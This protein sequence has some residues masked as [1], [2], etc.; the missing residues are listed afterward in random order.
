MLRRSS[1]RAFSSTTQTTCFPFSDASISAG[2][3]AE[4][5]L[6]RYTVVFSVDDLRIR[7]GRADERL[8]ARRERVV[9]VLHDDVAARDL[10]EE[11]VVRPGASRRW[12]YGTHGSYFRSGRSSA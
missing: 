2:A 3:S 6:V 1:K 4:S 7:R 5:W 11:V 12:V 8:D 10:L 9:R